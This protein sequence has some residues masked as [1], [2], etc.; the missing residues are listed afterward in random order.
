MGF[1]VTINGITFDYT[2]FYP[3]GYITARPDS[4]EALADEGTKELTGLSTTNIKPD[5]DKG[6]TKAITLPAGMHVDMTRE[7][8]FYNSAGNFISGLPVAYNQTT[9]VASIQ[10]SSTNYGGAASLASWQ[11]FTDH[12]ATGTTAVE[13]AQCSIGLGY[14]QGWAYVYGNQTGVLEVDSP[15]FLMAEV[16]ED[17]INGY[18]FNSGNPITGTLSTYNREFGGMYMWSNS[19][20]AS[21]TRTTVESGTL[22][23]GVVD[24]VAT[25][26]SDSVTLTY[27]K[28]PYMAVYGSGSSQFD[29][30][31][32]APTASTTDEKFNCYVGLKAASNSALYDVLDAY[33]VGFVYTNDVNGGYWVAVSTHRGVRTY[34]FSN[35]PASAWAYLRIVADSNNQVFRFYAS[36]TADLDS[37]APILTVA[38]GDD[39]L[40]SMRETLLHPVL[41]IWK[42]NGSSVSG[43][44]RVDY[45]YNSK[46]LWRL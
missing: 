2:D 31:A 34:G 24:M 33:G 44:L 40:S 12:P 8:M 39:Y 21:V 1:P 22:H 16:F 35:V 3:L 42:T 27:G 4:I 46:R 14:G 38:M 25:A 30:A 5:T 37:V 6:T 45:F 13:L 29:V 32:Y 10:L 26:L 36:T 28:L 15:R 41:S 20:T 23:P 17:F 11:V 18:N 43:T 19:S 7:L 9:G